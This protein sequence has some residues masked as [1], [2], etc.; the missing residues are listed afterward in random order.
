MPE[1]YEDNEKEI[2][3]AISDLQNEK[4]DIAIQLHGGGR[5]SNAFLNKIGAT[6]TVG[7]RTPDA[8][9]LDLWIPY[10]YYQKEIFRYIEVVSLLG[11]KTKEFEPHIE[12]T[13]QDIDEANRV[14]SL[15][16]FVVIHVGSTD[17]RRRWPAAK[18]AELI[19]ALSGKYSIVLTGTSDEE[20]TIQS[21]LEL[22][23]SKP[24]NLCNQ[25]SL[26]GLTGIL[27]KAQLVISNDTGPLHLATALGT[28]TLG[29]YWAPNC[30]NWAPMTKT[31]NR[32]VIAWNT[33]CSLCGQN[34]AQG[35]PFDT[36]TNC[37]HQISFV[38]E[39]V[40]SDVLEEAYNLLTLHIY[41]TE[42]HSS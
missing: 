23:K 1:S 22:C 11:L 20:E 14:I 19:D 21:V 15:D 16:S 25:L 5:Y 32:V 2:D 39:I 27:A 3:Q 4:F 9:E 13:Q 12:I 7:M 24:I 26:Q 41:G 30:I 6:T 29:I 38:D 40:V 35:Y 18:F 31:Q 33:I 42:K 28:P 17:R 34:C 36:Q 37:T 8:E 10:V